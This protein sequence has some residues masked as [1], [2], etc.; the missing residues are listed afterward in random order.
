MIAGIFI[1]GLIQG[2]DLTAIGNIIARADRG[3]PALPADYEQAVIAT[4]GL[5]GV[6]SCRAVAMNIHSDQEYYFCADPV[7][8]IANR[9][10]LV[11][12]SPAMLQINTAEARQLVSELSA[13]FS[14][15]GM[16]FNMLSPQ[17]WIVSVKE[18]PGI[19]C[20]SLDSV[21]GRHILE[22]LPKG[23]NA[24]QWHAMLTEAQSLMHMS[25]INDQRQQAGL[26]PIN[27]IWLWGNGKHPDVSRFKWDALYADDVLAAGLA[28]AAGS[29]IAPAE[30]INWDAVDSN[31]TLL[32]ITPELVQSVAGSLQSYEHYCNTVYDI[33]LKPALSAIKNKTLTEL[34]VYTEACP[35]F[36]L[37]RNMLYRWWRRN[38]P[39]PGY[40]QTV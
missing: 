31:K 14:D 9:D 17:Q 18:K 12:D 13:H 2:D 32:I 37:R 33:W 20:K 35:P 23:K 19:D 11:L 5:E 34:V 8:L 10:Q 7:H 27:S 6:A 40:S 28:Q 15:D 29:S 39:L 21:I 25:A 3:S 1:S 26:V 30:A 16:R 36:V 24:L 4:L 38:R 22:Y